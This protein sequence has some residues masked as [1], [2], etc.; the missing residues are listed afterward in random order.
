[1]FKTGLPGLYWTGVASDYRAHKFRGTAAVMA[2]VQIAAG[3][4]AGALS[5][6]ANDCSLNSPMV[7]LCGSHRK[8]SIKHF[9]YKV[10]APSSV[11]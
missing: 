2:G 7:H 9:T 11:N 6:L 4:T 3:A 10:V 8:P 5:K 1:M